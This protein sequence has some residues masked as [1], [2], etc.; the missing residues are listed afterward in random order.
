MLY[1]YFKRGNLV[2]PI[3]LTTL[4]V[5]LETTQAQVKNPELEALKKE[6]E[7]L[8]RSDAEKQ[9]KLDEL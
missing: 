1:S 8:R 4:F 2:V 7:E 6:I 5:G 9:R 3:L